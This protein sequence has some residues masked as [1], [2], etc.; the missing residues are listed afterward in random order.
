MSYYDKLIFCNA[1]VGM[2]TGDGGNAWEDFWKRLNVVPAPPR[3]PRPVV[4]VGTEQKRQ[5]EALIGTEDELKL[6]TQYMAETGDN[7]WDWA[8]AFARQRT[9]GGL[10]AKTW[11][12]K[13]RRGLRTR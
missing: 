8:K 3:P 10:D 5:R 9:A 2:V 4:D 11:H 6:A 7:D 12:Q 13:N 1:D